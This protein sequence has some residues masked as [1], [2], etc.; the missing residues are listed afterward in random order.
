GKV[1]NVE[2][3]AEWLLRA[4]LS[5]YAC[6]LCNPASGSLVSYIADDARW[7]KNDDEVN[8]GADLGQGSVVGED[9]IT[10]MH[11]IT[12]SGQR[13]ANDRWK[14]VVGARGRSR[15]DADRLIRKSHWQR[16]TIGI[17]LANDRT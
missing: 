7:W 9:G 11:G 12:T 3:T 10:W 4:G 5:R 14:V 15:P 8:L 13:S 6:L 1:S 16:V 17:A 2:L